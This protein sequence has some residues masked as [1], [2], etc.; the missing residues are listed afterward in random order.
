[1]ETLEILS[2]ARAVA[3]LRRSLKQAAK[4]IWTQQGDVFSRKEI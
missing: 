3:S 2:D 1:M 4:G